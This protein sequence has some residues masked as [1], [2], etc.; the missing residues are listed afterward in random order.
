M[1]SN[2]EI[3]PS[4]DS[5]LAGLKL[6]FNSFT[7]GGFGMSVIIDNNFVLSRYGARMEVDSLSHHR[8]ISSPALKKVEE[9]LATTEGSLSSSVNREKARKMLYIQELLLRYTKLKKTL[10]DFKMD[11]YTEKEVDTL[12]EKMKGKEAKFTYQPVALI[13]Q[14]Q[15]LFAEY[16]MVEHAWEKSL[17][18]EKYR[19]FFTVETTQSALAKAFIACFIDQDI[20]SNLGELE[21]M[22]AE[23]SKTKEEKFDH[24]RDLLPDHPVVKN[25]YAI[26]EATLKYLK[27]HENTSYL[28]QFW[29]KSMTGVT[30]AQAIRNLIADEQSSYQQL[31]NQ[32]KLLYQASDLSHHAFSRYLYAAFHPEVYDIY[33]LSDKDFKMLKEEFDKRSDQLF[34]EKSMEFKPK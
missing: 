20:V 18:T 16:G 13:P 3:R 34:V 5:A 22:A 6:T 24:L 23:L 26:Q 1:R 2:I 4:R 9:D 15:T 31:L 25:S 21:K 32:A 28:T 11:L 14:L 33:K 12:A 29:N 30:H 19:I 27:K 7:L 8:L 17:A 10:S